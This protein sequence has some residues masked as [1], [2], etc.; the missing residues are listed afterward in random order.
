MAVVH[1]QMDVLE[2]LLFIASH[3]RSLQ[4]VINEQNALYQVCKGGVF[5]FLGF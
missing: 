4:A 1:G 5:R 2:G 3:D